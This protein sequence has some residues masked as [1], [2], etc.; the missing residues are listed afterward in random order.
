MIVLQAAT[1]ILVAVIAVAF[2]FDWLV[3]RRQLRE[4]GDELTESEVQQ[5]VYPNGNVHLL[6]PADQA[7]AAPPD[8][9]KD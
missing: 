5:H 4:L 8:K 1:S 2:A 6:T 7:E 9:G 3:E